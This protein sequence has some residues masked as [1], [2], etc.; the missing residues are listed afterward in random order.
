M[1]TMLVFEPKDHKYYYEGKEIPS[2]S[3]IVARFYEPFDRSIAKFVAKAKKTTEKKLLKS[4]DKTRDDAL[5]LGN[6]VHDFAEQ[7][8]LGNLRYPTIDHHLTVIKLHKDLTE[9][10]LEIEAC[11]KRLFNKDYYYAGTT[12]LLLKDVDGKYIVADFK[13]NAD[14]YKESGKKMKEPFKQLK[15]TPLNKYKI[16][17]SLYQMALELEGFDIKERWIIWIKSDKYTI[18]PTANYRKLLKQYFNENQ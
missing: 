5:E 11:E 6:S 7:W 12:D 8:F 3:S 13:T 16:Q 17:I 2:V 9:R 4:W 15:E 18:I 1:F 14:L 10:G